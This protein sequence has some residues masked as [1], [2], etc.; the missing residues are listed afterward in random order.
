M[1]SGLTGKDHE[2]NFWSDEEVLHLDLGDGYTIE[3]IQQWA[4]SGSHA[5]E[6][7]FLNNQD[8]FESRLL[9]HC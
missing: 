8:N 6:R 4:E 7:Q 1:R 5:P 9:N 3:Y 2:G